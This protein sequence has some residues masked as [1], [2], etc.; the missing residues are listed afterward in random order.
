M[1]YL[2]FSTFN[3]QLSTFLLC[4]LPFT[5]FSQKQY[6]LGECER[7]AL[8]NNHKIKNAHLEV[9]AASQAKKE[10]VTA[11]FPQI[12]ATGT[13]FTANKGLLR[14]NIA[15]PDELSAA[16]PIIP[17]NIPVSLLDDG[18]AG[19][20][21]ATQPIFAG[22]RI[23]M[24][25]KLAK[26]GEDVANVQLQLS[27]DEVVLTT[28]R[29]YY[30][31]V[32]L[33]EQL[34]TLAVTDSLL[35][36]I[37]KDVAASVKAGLINRNDLLRVELQRQEVESNGLTVNNNIQII[38]LLLGQHIGLED[39]HY[40]IEI[41][42]QTTY[43]LPVTYYISPN[44]AV[45]LRK[46]MK[47]LDFNVDASNLMTKMAGAERLPSV[48]VGAGYVHHDLLNKSTNTG[49]VY[50]TVSIPISDWWGKSHAQKNRHFKA[51]QA[52]NDRNNATEL[53]VVEISKVWNELVE[54][55]NQILLAE[56]SIESANE[57]LRLNRNSYQAGTVSM[58]DLLDAQVIF[59]QSSNQLST[60]KCNYAL[61]LAE[62]KII[63]GQM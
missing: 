48:A 38:K 26:I 42:Q 30:Q 32:Q 4:C 19:A 6:T 20:V 27:H 3:F 5:A 24:G 59:Q 31:L 23:V 58:N 1:K 45:Q 37:Q 46:E 40:E 22:G 55:Y 50:A 11:Y 33:N 14:T 49:I 17:S 15:V 8:E 41:D 10:A 35:A 9:G 57:N 2:T 51:R 47:L 7:L 34:K 28:K 21:T 52:E 16:M 36:N 12:S 62:Y 60:A 44:Q 39:E 29:Y 18:V 54:S 13:W 61:K 25:N 63:T 56:K 43:N 53:M